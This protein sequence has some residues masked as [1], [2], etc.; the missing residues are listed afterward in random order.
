ERGA[1]LRHSDLRQLATPIACSMGGSWPTTSRLQRFAHGSWLP[2]LECHIE[3]QNR[4]LP[5]FVGMDHYPVGLETIEAPQQRAAPFFAATAR[6][7]IGGMSPDGYIGGATPRPTFTRGACS[8]P[9]GCFT[10]AAMKM[11][12]P[13]FSS[14]FSPGK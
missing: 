14:S 1:W 2:S 10:A 11:L 3:R 6:V 7:G 12:V 9:S 8:V 13:G 5:T 4:R